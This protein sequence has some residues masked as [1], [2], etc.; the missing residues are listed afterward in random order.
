MTIYTQ[1]IEACQPYWTVRDNDKH[2]PGSYAFARKLL[3]NYPNADAMI[4]LPAILMHDNGYANV[5][6]E[7]L[8]A[9]LT[10]SPNGFNADITR[11]HEIEGAKIARSILIKLHFDSE[12]I[13]TICE[14]IDGHDSR[15]DALSLED[16]LVKDSDK[17]WRF[18]AEAAVVAGQGWMGREP[19]EFLDYCLSKLE[20]WMFLEESVELAKEAA[21]IA[22]QELESGQN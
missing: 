9:G 19:L 8:L 22:R 5:P 11:L 16:K 3:D 10:D 14:I 7:T 4:V 1:I 21:N 13:E 12:K 18:T 15:K 2:I 6:P 20:G 17:L